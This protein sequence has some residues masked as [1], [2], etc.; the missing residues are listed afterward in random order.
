MLDQCAKPYPVPR[1][2]ASSRHRTGY[3]PKDLVNRLV[4]LCL[5]LRIWRMIDLDRWVVKIFVAPFVERPARPGF[6]RGT[7]GACIW[8]AFPEG[9]KVVGPEYGSN[10]YCSACNNPVEP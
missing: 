10:L 2:W 5:W 3:C 1:K 9:F 6:R 8:V 7:N 4:P